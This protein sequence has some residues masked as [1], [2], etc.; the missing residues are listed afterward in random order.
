MPAN[1]TPEYFEAEKRFRA[2]KTDSERVE[3]LQFMLRVIPKHKGTDKMQGDL[4]RRIAKLKD[5][6]EQQQRSSKKKGVSHKLH[7]E[8][9]GTV[10]LVGPPNVGK[11]LLFHVLTGVEAK[12]GAYPYTTLEPQ[13]GMMHFENVQIQLVDFPPVCPEHTE[14]WVFDLIKSCDAVLLIIDVGQGDPLEQ[15]ETT[16]NLLDRHNFVPLWNAEDVASGPAAERRARVVANKVDAPGAKETLQLF[17]EMIERPLPVTPVSGVEGTSVEGLKREI[18]DLLAVM[19]VYSKVPH[20]PPELDSPFTIP[21]GATLIDF[22]QAV[23][24]D[25]ARNLKFGKVW[26]STKFD[27]MVVKRDYVLQEGDVVELHA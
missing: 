3:C 23:H 13:P 8:G 15:F 26:G 10:A 9:A 27:G 20:Q 1:L 19:R 7:K 18:F 5:K 11:S 17:R 4:K 14:S 12:T 24:Q 6:I 2:A 22:A 16:M 25:F 21:R